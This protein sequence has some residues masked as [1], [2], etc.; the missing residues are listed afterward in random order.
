MV[1]ILCGVYF[2]DNSRTRTNSR[3]K[4]KTPIS[5]VIRMEPTITEFDPMPRCPRCGRLMQ[6]KRRTK[7]WG[8]PRC[9]V[10]LTP[11]ELAGQKTSTTESNMFAAA[12][13]VT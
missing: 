5:Y 13:G 9:D 4:F 3:G 7:T 11:E 6:W 12:G 2:L 1:C 10:S 8:C